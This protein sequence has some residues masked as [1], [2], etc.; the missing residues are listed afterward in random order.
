MPSFKDILLKGYSKLNGK[1]D[2]LSEREKLKIKGRVQLEIPYHETR[3]QCIY[4][5]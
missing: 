4:R 5:C 2:A 3:T 1:L